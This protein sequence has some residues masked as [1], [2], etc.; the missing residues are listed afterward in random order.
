MNFLF[1]IFYFL[2][3]IILQTIIIPDTFFFG[4]CFDLVVIP[5]VFLS[6]NST[7]YSV[8]FSIILIGCIMDS[9]SGVLFSYNIFSYLWIYIIVTLARQI[10]VQ[11][12]FV[13]ILLISLF[14]V[15][16]QDFLMLFINFVKHGKEFWQF[17]FSFFTKYLFVHLIW[18]LMFIPFGI[19]FTRICKEQ[20]FF[21]IQNFTTNMA[22]KYREQ[23]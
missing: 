9:I 17:E 13:F 15:L 3:L 5:I 19:W 14:S 20:W 21:V 8:I 12:S 10:V 23:I 7:R 4:Y 22:K 2:F 16:I 11:Q 6:L 1:F 18:G